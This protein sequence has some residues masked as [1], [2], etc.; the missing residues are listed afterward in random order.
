MWK[1]RVG[2]KRVGKMRVRD[3]GF[4]VDHTGF[5]FFVSRCVAWYGYKYWDAVFVTI[6]LLGKACLLIF[7]KNIFLLC[8]LSL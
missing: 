8:F 5:A 4:N 1:V 3:L 7:E 2:F 6:V